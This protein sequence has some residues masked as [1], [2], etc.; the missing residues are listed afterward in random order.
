MG[1]NKNLFDNTFGI[2]TIFKDVSGLQPGN[3]IRFAGINV[4][5]IENIVILN[6]TAVRVDLQIQESVHRFIKEDS[7]AIIGS[8]GIMG[9]K[10]L[11]ISPGTSE[12]IVKRKA[13]IQS[14]A[15]LNMDE[16]LAN[17]K[18]TI[19]NAAIMTGDLSEITTT[20][21]TGKGTIGKLFMDST[22]AEDIDKTV[23]NIRQS[24]GGLKENMEAA[25]SN[26]LFRGYFRRKEKEKEKE[27]QQLQEQKEKA[28]SES[29]EVKSSKQKTDTTSSKK[30]RRNRN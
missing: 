15:P 30:N 10:I 2:S 8:E 23:G 14:L 16:I 11:I 5:I 26:I 20:I 28:K 17:L 9:N 22:L 18:T 13:V 6:D 7:K 25:K 24:A 12:K 4:G 29:E 21:R 19:E 27:Q 3:N 1:K